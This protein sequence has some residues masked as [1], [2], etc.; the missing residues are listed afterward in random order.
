MVSMGTAINF[1]LPLSIG[2]VL[3]VS[4][5]LKTRSPA[6]TIEAIDAFKLP[7]FLQNRTVALSFSLGEALLGLAILF[8]SA[9]PLRVLSALATLLFAGF[10]VLVALV[11]F[12]KETV[13]CNCFGSL[14]S[15]P[16]SRFTLVRNLALLVGAALL[17]TGVAGSNGIAYEFIHFTSD[18]FWWLA[19][20]VL[21]VAGLVFQQW[22]FH[23]QQD[24][25]P[26]PTVVN[27]PQGLRD[28]AGLPI[29]EAELRNISLET[30]KLSEL[31]NERPQLLIFVKPGCAS[32][33]PVVALIEQWREQLN[34]DVEIS[35]VS[36]DSQ[37][38]L[39]QSYPEE[40][41]AALH[42]ESSQLTQLLGI[43]GVPAALM[44]GTNGMVAAG[45]VMGEAAITNV[46][47]IV[48]ESR[49]SYLKSQAF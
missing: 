1:L 16:L 32:C 20:V 5:S 11:L 46:V 48:V 27:S 8:T 21:C 29:P 25:V 23:S 26:P 41:S 43:S 35:L 39:G 38:I 34:D 3:I 19:V 13:D 28:L 7:K 6:A 49:L 14:S 2:L 4:G 42:D 9:T 18:D 36:T 40:Q 33:K 47:E 44:L 15:E 45:P 30:V 17:A 22:Y 12:R 24:E 37:N 10:T 31:S